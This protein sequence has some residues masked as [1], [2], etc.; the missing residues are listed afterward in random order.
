MKKEKEKEQTNPT[1]LLNGSILTKMSPKL[2]H[3]N[4]SLH[5]KPKNKR[6]I[7]VLGDTSQE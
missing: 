3:Q 4:S 7:S 6:M 5:N 1:L 2:M